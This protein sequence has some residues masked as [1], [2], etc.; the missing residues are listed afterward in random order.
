[1]NETERELDLALADALQENKLL[2]AQMTAEV[3]VLTELVRV[4][5]DKVA[6]LEAVK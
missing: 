5:S 4:L 6:E 3:T 2:R 1:M